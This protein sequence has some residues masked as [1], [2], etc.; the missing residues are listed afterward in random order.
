[1]AYVANCSQNC[2]VVGGM[3]TL[4]EMEQVPTDAQDKPQVHLAHF[5]LTSSMFVSPTYIGQPYYRQYSII[6]MCHALAA[7]LASCVI[8]LGNMYIE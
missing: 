1:M 4:T 2:R 7:M 6:L 3:E 8:I 5:W